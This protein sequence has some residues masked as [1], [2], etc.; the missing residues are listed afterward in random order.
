MNRAYRL[1]AFIFGTL[2]ILAIGV[3]Q[4]GNEDLLFS[5]TYRLK[6]AFPNVGGLDNGAEVRV[7]GIH[8]G[9][10]RQ[11]QLPTR[12]GEKMTVVMDV[13]KSTRDIIKKDSVASIH[14]EGLLG[15]KFVEI[16]FGSA[17]APKVEDGDT[18]GG[19]PP[20]DFSE[21][22][23]KADQILDSTKETMNN[24]SATTDNLKAVSSKIN[25]GK[26]TVGALINDKQIYEQLDAA[27]AQAKAGATA[28]QED[29][30]ALKHNFFLRGFFN[31][32]GYNDSSELTKHEIA[33]LPEGLYIKKFVY[34]PKQTFRKPDSAK[35]KNEKALNE[36]G[37]FL[38]QNKFGLAV[39]A[40]SSGAKGDADKNLVLTEAR[41]KA[42]R[43][44][45]VKNFKMD[46]T[47]LMTMGLGKKGPA[48]AGDDGA[49]EIMIYPVGSSIPP[50]TDLASSTR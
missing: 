25:Q 48:D 5:S 14:T 40:A 17:D 31:K 16:S 46:D 2:L 20:L 35:L 22:I 24:A 33:Y 45:L 13:E 38:E 39:V 1:G 4:I 9:T 44:Y 28:F 37:R 12:P 23:E 41:A 26:G 6:A 3:F 49:V 34:D 18:V 15:S 21:L 7:G 8:K 50:A 27:A 36:A 32:R 47:R 30:E 42:V 43:D 10:V 29:M 11:I 19:E